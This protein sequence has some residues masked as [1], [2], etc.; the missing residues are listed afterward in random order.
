MKRVI[1]IDEDMTKALEQGSFG[2]K[3]NMYD[4]VGCVMN[5]ISFDEVLDKI[6][7]EFEQNRLETIKLMNTPCQTKTMQEFKQQER[8]KADCDIICR[9]LQC[10]ID[11]INKYK[12]SE[13]K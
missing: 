5:S 7:N 9:T 6:A 3:Y 10:A 2:V 13:D 8:Y 12:E 11:I 1:E 4:L